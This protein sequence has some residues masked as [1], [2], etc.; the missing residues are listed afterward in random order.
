MDEFPY[1]DCST[2][3]TPQNIDIGKHGM[4]ECSKN[5]KFTVLRLSGG[6]VDSLHFQLN[7]TLFH[8]SKRL[9][10]AGLSERLVL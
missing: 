9:A 3:L 4:F 1:A 10:Y 5:M 8:E 2:W 6:I 7:C